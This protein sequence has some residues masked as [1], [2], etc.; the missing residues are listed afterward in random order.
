[1][2]RVI[3]PVSGLVVRKACENRRRQLPLNSRIYLVRSAKKRP[4]LLSFGLYETALHE[5]IYYKLI[6][7]SA[8]SP[9]QDIIRRKELLLFNYYYTTRAKSCKLFFKIFNFFFK[10]LVFWPFLVTHSSLT[11]F[12]T[13]SYGAF[14]SRLL[15][16][17][18]QEME[19]LGCFDASS[20]VQKHAQMPKCRNRQG[21]NGGNVGRNL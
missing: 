6:K 3:P 5:K 7:I 20:V 2:L 14:F 17:D 11:P 1:M 19:I 4:K 10:K 15:N 16:A 18:F 9:N 8:V 13:R 12:G 21:K